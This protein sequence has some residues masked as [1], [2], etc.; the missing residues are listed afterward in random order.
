MQPI[1]SS[2]VQSNLTVVLPNLDTLEDS[3][4]FDP[5]S[6]RFMLRN[7]ADQ[8]QATYVKGSIIRDLFHSYLKVHIKEVDPQAVGYLFSNLDQRITEIEKP[9]HGWKGLVNSILNLPLIQHWSEQRDY[10]YAIQNIVKE[11]MGQF[12]LNPAE[13]LTQRSVSPSSVGSEESSLELPTSPPTSVRLMSDKGSDRSAPE[14]VASRPFSPAEELSRSD[15]SSPVPAESEPGSPERVKMLSEENRRLQAEIESLRRQMLA[16]AGEDEAQGPVRKPF[17]HTAAQLWVGCIADALDKF[18]KPNLTDA[19]KTELN[20]VLTE[21]GMTEFDGRGNVYRVKA[22][23]SSEAEVKTEAYCLRKLQNWLEKQENLLINP[24]V[25]EG[26]THLTDREM[27]S[28]LV[29]PKK[30]AQSNE[31]AKRYGLPQRSSLKD[32]GFALWRAKAL[33]LAARH[34]LF[35][36]MD[37]SHMQEKLYQTEITKAQVAVQEASQSDQAKRAW[38]PTPAMPAAAILSKR[39]L[40]SLPIIQSSSPKPPPPPPP[41]PPYKK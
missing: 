16:G 11:R 39:T 17:Q 37:L 27:D 26:F 18:N 22:F 32:V 10:L 1:S 8:S 19:E 13:Q 12:S 23:R 5:T 33:E 41:T 3:I 24:D 6:E 30:T 21:L 28:Y 7:D 25:A 15:T 4:V 31:I 35:N 9:M 29:D 38:N 40:T 2:S 36:I 34:K 20:K 14:S